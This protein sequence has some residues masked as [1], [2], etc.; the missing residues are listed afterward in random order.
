ML[1]IRVFCVGKPSLHCQR[2]MDWL[3]SPAL[4]GNR[5]QPTSCTQQPSSRQGT[6]ACEEPTAL[7]CASSSTS[8]RGGPTP[9]DHTRSA[10]LSSLRLQHHSRLPLFC[11]SS[12]AASHSTPTCDAGSDHG[13]TFSKAAARSQF[14]GRCARPE[15]LKT[16][17]LGCIL[18]PAQTPLN[19]PPP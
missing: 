7:N 3:L 17:W 16:K 18:L 15:G 11:P 10:T 14:R 4:S 5:G 13:V 1:E 9:H 19:P 8:W 12:L 2:S 6:R